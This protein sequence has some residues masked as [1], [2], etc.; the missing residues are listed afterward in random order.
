MQSEELFLA[1]Q[2]KQED[3][4]SL[5]FPVFGMEALTALQMKATNKPSSRILLSKRRVLLA[6]VAN[7][8]DNRVLGLSL[9][10]SRSF[11]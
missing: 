11:I 5:Q 8:H 4:V 3:S 7:C 2:E 6:M 10:G 1:T 9:K